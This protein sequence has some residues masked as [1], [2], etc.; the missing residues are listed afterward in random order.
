MFSIIQFIFLKCRSAF[1]YCRE[2]DD[3]IE[4]NAVKFLPFISAVKI[5]SFIICLNE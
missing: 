2:A 5:E 1:A 4:L 3:G